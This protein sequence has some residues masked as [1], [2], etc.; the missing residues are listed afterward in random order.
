MRTFH[1]AG[2]IADGTFRRAVRPGHLRVSL[3]IGAESTYVRDLEG[4]RI[5]RLNFQEAESNGD[6]FSVDFGVY[7]HL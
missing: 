2:T 3:P 6:I 4:H 5:R 1:V 7:Q